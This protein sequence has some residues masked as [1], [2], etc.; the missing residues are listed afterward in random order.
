MEETSITCI[1]PPDWKHLYWVLIVSMLLSIVTEHRLV[2]HTLFALCQS[3]QPA[4]FTLIP[5]NYD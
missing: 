5:C 3:E 2:T 4:M 1:K